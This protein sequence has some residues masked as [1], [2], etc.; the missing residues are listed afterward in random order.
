MHIPFLSKKDHSTTKKTSSEKEQFFPVCPNCLYPNL[1]FV[2]EFTSGWLTTP[3]YYCPNCRY[4]GPLFLE[5][6]IK[7]LETKTP[8]ELRKMFLEEE[9]EQ[10]DDTSSDSN[11]DQDEESF[12]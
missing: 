3:R 1:K 2:H 4:S 10:L 8:K 12:P 9:F 7:L 11:S 6:D 5:I